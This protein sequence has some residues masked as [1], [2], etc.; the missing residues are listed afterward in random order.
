MYTAGS[1]GLGEKPC[2]RRH[3]AKVF[4]VSNGRCWL[5]SVNFSEAPEA[6]EHSWDPTRQSGQ[7]RKPRGVERRDGKE[8]VNK[9]SIILEQR[10]G[11]ENVE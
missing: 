10:E 3:E 11:E 4:Q 5:E 8:R 1:A 2:G 6:E 9:T 7:R